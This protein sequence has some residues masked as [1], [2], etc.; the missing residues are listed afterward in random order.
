MKL[1]AAIF[2]SLFC[3][4]L[5]MANTG[6][7]QVI[8]EIRDLVPFGDKVGHVVIYGGLT[9][10]VNY[11]FSFRHFANKLLQQ[12]GS[13]LVLGFSFLEECSQYFIVTRTFSMM[14]MLANV[15][16]ISL[17][18]V[19]SMFCAKQAVKANIRS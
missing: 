14:D 16:G 4:I 11:A 12:Y 19:I 13:L 10:L 18:T 1:I 2:F 5:F 15:I 9:L 7:D 6:Q 17:F 8:G 3:V